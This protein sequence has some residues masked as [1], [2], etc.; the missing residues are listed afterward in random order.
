MTAADSKPRGPLAAISAVAVTLIIMLCGVFTASAF[1]SRLSGTTD[2]LTGH[3]DA[4]SVISRNACVTVHASKG[5]W[6]GLQVLT[7][8]STGKPVIA[9][10]KRGTQIVRTKFKGTNANTSPMASPD[11]T[12]AA[13]AAPQAG[14]PAWLQ[15]AYDMSALSASGGTDETVGI[16]DAFGDTTA[17]ADL[18]SYRANFGLPACTVASGCLTITNDQGQT[19]PLPSQGTGANAEWQTETTLDLEAVSALC[20]NCKIILVQVPSGDSME[21]ADNEAYALG[22]T[23]ISDS[24]GQQWTSTGGT[25]SGITD[26]GSNGVPVLASS[27]DGGYLGTIDGAA[28]FQIP[29]NFNDVT[30]VGGTDLTNDPTVARGFDETAWDGSGSSCAVDPDWTAISQPSWQTSLNTGCA[31]KAYADLSADASPSTGLDIYSA[32]FAGSGW[33]AVGGTSLAAPLTAAYYAIM[34]QAGTSGLNSSQW[35]YTNASL[36]NDITSGDNDDLVYGSNTC[37]SNALIECDAGTGWDGPTG[38]GTISGDSLTG[39]PGIG[40]DGNITASTGT[41]VTVGGGVYSNKLSTSAYIQYGTTTNYGSQTSAMSVTDDNGASAWSQSLTGLTADT[42]YDYRIVATNADGTT[43]GYNSTFTTAGAP[44]DATISSSPAAGTSSSTVSESFNGTVNDQGGSSG[45]WYIEYGTTT[46]YGSQTTAQ[47]LSGTTDISIT[48]TITGLQPDTTYHYKLVAQNSVG[49][50][51]TSDQTFTTVN[52][53]STSA[54]SDPTFNGDYISCSATVDTYGEPSATYYVEWG[55]TTAYGTQSTPSALSGSAS[56]TITPDLSGFVSNTTYHMAVVVST[57]YGSAVSA[58]LQFTTPNLPSASLGQVTGITYSTATL[59]GTANAEGD[60]G[61]AEFYVSTSP[62]MTNSL[63]EGITSISGSSDVPM[64]ASLPNLQPST[65]YYYDLYAE[66]TT[67][68]YTTAVQSFTTE[69]APFPVAER[70]SLTGT[71]TNSATCSAEVNLDGLNDV[72]GYVYYGTS[73][74]N[75]ATED[76]Q[77]AFSGTGEQTIRC[78][79]DNLEPGTTYYYEL[80]LNYNDQQY[81]VA[82]PG[83]FTTPPASTSGGG[84]TGGSGGGTTGGSGGSAPS[85]PVLQSVSAT[86]PQTGEA[87]ISIQITGSGNTVATVQ[88]GTSAGKLNMAATATNGHVVLTGLAPS[89][90]YYYKVTVGS[91]TT[92]VKSFTTPARAVLKKRVLKKGRVELM[93]S[94]TGKTACVIRTQLRVTAKRGQSVVKTVNVTVKPKKTATVTIK[95]SDIMNS[96]VRASLDVYEISGSQQTYIAGFDA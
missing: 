43:Y 64:S 34:T 63:F 40:S 7:N 46:S 77:L 86:V 15:W 94:C 26:P 47:S 17:A 23:V 33:E 32:Q 42:T 28:Y 90:T 60:S 25:P 82:G 12:P 61:Q 53:P 96:K 11:I 3:N 51:S 91:Q 89:T 31:G 13:A 58:D 59:N 4:G 87:L 24:W 9:S 57:E 62:E 39:A 38:N 76:G 45:T 66:T 35:P 49:I 1:A 79:M 37:P 6:C 70:V 10:V 21:A 18:A 83:P 2:S 80:V 88:Y 67:G 22:A 81:V 19:S 69:A 71:T 84:T 56:Q 20:P 68:S 36:L 27:G 30:S 95:S 8:K 44:D 29:D 93:F 74:S 55:H 73:P 72:S 14:T 92:A 41:T 85:G 52:L 54:C 50:A 75:M 5:Q 16:V 78:S 65:T 48:P